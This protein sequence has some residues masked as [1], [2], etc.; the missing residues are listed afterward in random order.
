M[1]PLRIVIADD[2]PMARQRLRRLIERRSDCRLVGSFEDG[3]GLIVAL[4]G[5]AADCVLLD[6][7]MPGPDGFATLAALARPLPPIVFVTAFDAFAAR[8]YDV[9]AVDYLLKPV[10]AAR[11]DAALDRVA[12]R[13]GRPGPQAA[14]PLPPS[15]CFVVQGRSYLFDPA[16]LISIQAIG[17]Y[18]A[19]TA[20]NRTLQLRMTL[21]EAEARLDANAFCRVHRSWI[22]A[23]DAMAQVTSLPGARFDILLRDGRHVPGGRAYAGAVTAAARRSA[24]R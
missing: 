7:S 16:Q 10:S 13:L 11:L 4:P 15:I 19:I 8:A 21:S 5:L 12:R 2:E 23:R 22:V 3:A 14:A 6:I 20:D 9:D 18:V 24:A 17:N 1:T